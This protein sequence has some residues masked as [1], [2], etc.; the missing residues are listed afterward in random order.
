M[1]DNT[2]E[3]CRIAPETGIHALWECGVV[4]DVWANS[5]VSLQ[6]FVGGQCDSVQ[7]FEELLDCLSMED[8]ELFLVQ[9]WLI[10]NQRNLIIHGGKF[11]EP[12]QLN[13]RASDYLVKFHQAQK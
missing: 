4:Q 11:Q 1:V 12:T 10:W 8:F 2:Y 3:L 13:K 7:L 6:K 5:F 9:A